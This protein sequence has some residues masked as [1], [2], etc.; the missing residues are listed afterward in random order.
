[1]PAGQFNAQSGLFGA[2]DEISLLCFILSV[3]VVTFL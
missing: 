2:I 1:M 3:H